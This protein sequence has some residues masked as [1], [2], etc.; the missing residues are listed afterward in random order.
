MA[1]LQ[2]RSC[3]Y[4]VTAKSAAVCVCVGLD[5]MTPRGGDCPNSEYFSLN[6]SRE[7]E[8]ASIFQWIQ[9]RKLVSCTA[10]ACV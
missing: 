9:A 10:S 3:Y 2:T 6:T 5:P 8:I 7:A 4:Q 1:G